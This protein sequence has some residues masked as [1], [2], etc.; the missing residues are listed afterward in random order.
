MEDLDF[1]DLMFVSGPA[2]KMIYSFGFKPKREDFL[3]MTAE[4]YKKYY[5]TEKDTGERMF[6]YLPKDPKE[7]AVVAGGKDAFAIA[8]S[9]IDLFDHAWQIV[10][11]YC[12]GKDLQDDDEKMA[13]A[14]TRLP[15]VFTEGTR[16]ELYSKGR[17][18]PVKS[19]KNQ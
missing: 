16:F 1:F 11:K 17:L 18:Y 14:A 12:Q 10:E 19:D 7:Y 6:L 3:E 8:E 5:E 15:D 9:D 4:Q 2:L 13:Y